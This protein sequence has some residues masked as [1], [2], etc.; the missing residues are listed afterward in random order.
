MKLLK[1]HNE[2]LYHDIN[3]TITSLK[4]AIEIFENSSDSDIDLVIEKIIPLS[5]D[6]LNEL[7][8][9]LDVYHSSK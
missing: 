1:N 5:V 4:S 7:K 9:L 2:K 6:K 8:Q 3:S